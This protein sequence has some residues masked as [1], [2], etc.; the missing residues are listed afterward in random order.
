MSFEAMI[1]PEAR[2]VAPGE[3]RRIWQLGNIFTMKAT[4]EQ[5]RRSY[6]LLEQE[7]AGAPP[8]RHVHEHDEEAFYVL[9]GTLDLFL[10][11]DV[12]PVVP[13]SFCLVPRGLAHTFRSTSEKPARMLVILSPPGFETFF[14]AC[15]QRFPE[16]AGMPEPAEAGAVL[17][18]MAPDFGLRIVGPPPE[19]NG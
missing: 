15:E 18:A 10:G 4:A 5:T 17:T 13:G 14:D 11:D 12:V 9:E 16:H 8:P 7:C 6:T 3:G 1:S 19:H 2:V